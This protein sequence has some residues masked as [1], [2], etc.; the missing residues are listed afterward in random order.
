MLSCTAVG[1]VVEQNKNLEESG[2]SPLMDKG[3]YR[4]LVGVLVYLS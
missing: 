4:G 2:E 1:N 3:W